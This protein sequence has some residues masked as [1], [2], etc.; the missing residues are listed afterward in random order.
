MHAPCLYN[1]ALPRCWHELSVRG[2]HLQVH[3]QFNLVLHLVDKLCSYA[4]SLLSA[5]AIM[6]SKIDQCMLDLMRF[7]GEGE[8][9]DSA[10]A[11]DGESLQAAA[12]SATVTTTALPKRADVPMQS[13]GD[14]ALAGVVD[15]ASSR[16]GDMQPQPLH[17]KDEG[18]F[19]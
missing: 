8:E 2:I 11:S 19:L 4:T 14:T 1:E 9:S 6:V 10:S 15:S 17:R 7:H 13:A 3:L 16:K 5:A 12:P 18:R